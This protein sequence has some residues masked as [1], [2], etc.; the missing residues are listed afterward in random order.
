MW[1]NIVYYVICFFISAFQ[2]V[3]VASLWDLEKPGRCLNWL[4][5]N[6]V[7]GAF[8]SVSDL[9]MLVFPLARIW[10]LQMSI[11]RKQGVTAIFLIGLL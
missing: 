7:T 10:T 3:P 8:N 4:A 5:Y 2:C 6:I 1:V 11:E 9:L